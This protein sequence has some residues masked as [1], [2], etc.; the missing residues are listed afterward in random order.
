M[1]INVKCICE[2]FHVMKKEIIQNLLVSCKLFVSLHAVAKPARHLVMQMHFFS[3]YI[4]YKESISNE[5]NNDNL[6]LHSMKV[7]RWLCY[8]VGIMVNMRK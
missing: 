2:V 4:P 3:V 1:I 6:N 7:S 8:T 5:M